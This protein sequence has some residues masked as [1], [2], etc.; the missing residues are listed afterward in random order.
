MVEAKVEFPAGTAKA[1]AVYASDGTETPAQLENGAVLFLAKAP[2]MGYTVYRVLPAQSVAVNETV[3][4]TESSLENAR[5][6]VQL[7]Q[8]GDVS[9]IYARA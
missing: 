4:V 2:S 9:S 3:K 8:D 6:R 7:N 5:Y 1:V